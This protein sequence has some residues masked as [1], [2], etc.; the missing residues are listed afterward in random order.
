MKSVKKY[1]TTGDIARYCEVDVNTV[2]SWIRHGSLQAFTTPSGHYRIARDSFIAFIKKQGFLYDAI[3]FGQ[4]PNSTGILVIDDD[5]V[6]RE[7]VL[8]VLGQMYE[9]MEI[10]DASNGFDGYRLIL[11]HR[12][13]LLLLDLVMPGMTGLELIRVIRSRDDL[14]DIKILVISAYLDKSTM[15]ELSKLHVDSVVA[16]PLKKAEL[17]QECAVLLPR[18]TLRE[19]I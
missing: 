4:E 15:D 18:A 8:H 2:K 14:N 16:K 6:H 1:F 9:E 19:K 3:Y 11:Q 5:P 7:L 17:K 12:P 10:K 13:R